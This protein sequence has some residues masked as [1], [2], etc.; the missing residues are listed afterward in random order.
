MAVAESRVG[1]RSRGSFSMSR[2]RRSH[3]RRSRVDR[4][5]VVWAGRRVWAARNH[6]DVRSYHMCMVAPRANVSLCVC[7]LRRQWP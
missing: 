5:E 1:R 3:D 7:G 2:A 4:P 6:I